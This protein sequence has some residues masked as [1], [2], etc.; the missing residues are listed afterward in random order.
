MLWA[1]AAALGFFA[2]FVWAAGVYPMGDTW[3]PVVL[4]AYA[5]LLWWRADLWLLA[6]PAL[7]P[8]LDLAP[9]TG[10]FFLEEIDLLLML[11]AGFAYWR[12]PRPSLSGNRAPRG[13]VGQ[14]QPGATDLPHWPPLFRV[15]LLLL[16]AAVALGLWRGLQ[17]WPAVDANTF[18]NY[19]SPANALR[20]GK[21]WFWALVLLPALRQAVGPQLEGV[22]Q[23]LIPG[24]L[25][26][27][28]L[29]AA[30]AI[31]ER[32][33]FTGL[34]NFSSDYRISAP[35]SAMHTGGAALDGYLALTIPLIAMW[36][37]PHMGALRK[38]VALLLLPLAWYVALATFSRGLYLG[39]VVTA[40]MFAARGLTTLGTRA[41]ALAIGAALAVLL[42]DAAFRSGG[43]RAF[44][45]LLLLLGVLILAA[46]QHAAIS[47]AALL[48]LGCAIPIYHGYYTNVRFASVDKDWATRVRHW[49]NA[50]AMVNNS[51]FGMGLGTFPTRYYWH[52]PQ[53]EVPPGYQFIDQAG[54]RH[55]RLSAGLYAA[56]YGELLRMLQDVTVQPRQQYLVAVDV[57][58]SGPPAF[59]HIN[60]CQR[61][62]LY[63]QNCVAVPLRQIPHAPEWQRYFY[64]INSGALGNN[65]LPLKLEIA[66]EG[67]QAMLDIDNVSLRAVPDGHELLRNGSFSNANTG[68]FFSSDRNHLPWHL[69]NLALNLYFETGWLG[70]GAYGLLLFSA[71]AVLLR[72]SDTALLAAFAAFHIVGLFDS[73]LEVPR[74]TLLSMLL[75][76]AAT[77][78]AKEPT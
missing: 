39:L 40:A 51:L 30:A 41:V 55:L 33:Q 22:R 6:L 37:A 66:A 1:R 28:A 27:L 35:F 14:R 65:K 68:W 45:P 57:S 63:P 74:I 11:T 19:L 78:Q 48:L 17:P 23:R 36:L 46:R 13:Q 16:G 64:P 67:Q 21:A 38:T 26:G 75:L 49:Q 5:C 59:L 70:L 52:N 47:L 20:V 69:K 9:Y 29:V 34:L 10:W 73:L 76:C 54:N 61:Q 60:L 24:M 8:V 3:L 42:L 43:Y 77:L 58:N 50:L 18:N 12:H 71:T 32:V 53:R 62:L 2:A 56:G 25:L 15:G 44:L 72:R 31:R 7:L 4:L